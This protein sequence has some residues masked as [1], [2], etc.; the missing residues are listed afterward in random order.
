VPHL[1]TEDAAENNV[2][3]HLRSLQAEDAIVVV[4]QSV[5][6]API[7]GPASLT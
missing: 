5:A 1:A 7:C 4:L 3:Q 2:V 6:H